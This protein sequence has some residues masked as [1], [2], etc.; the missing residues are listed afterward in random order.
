MIK[1]KHS[2][3]IEDGSEDGLDLEETRYPYYDDNFGLV[4]YTS[5]LRDDKGKF[6]AFVDFNAD[7]DRLR[8]REC[9]HCLE[10][11][12]HNK[13]GPKIKKKNE[14]PAPDDDQFLSCYSC[15]NTFGIHETHFNS[16]IIDSVETTSNPFD[17]ESTFLSTDSRATQ[18]KK[19]ERR[20]HY[21][22]GVHK[23]MSKRFDNEAN[24][25]PVIQKEI[26]I[27]GSDNVHII[28]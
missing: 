27:H 14:P 24:E 26:D 22:K 8:I 23:Y 6:F 10:Y 11:D 18:R 13:L 28:Q 3:T 2:L 17:N 7:D 20:D 25:D 4:G 5:E 19:R 9:P 16:K 1:E 21:R 15:G 12:I